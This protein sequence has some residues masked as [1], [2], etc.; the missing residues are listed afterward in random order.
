MEDEKQ[1]Q[2]QLQLTLQRRMEK[3]SPE[4][5]SE[6]LFKRGI[7]TFKCLLCGSED[8]G[9]PQCNLLQSGP[10]GSVSKTFVDYIKL[11]ADGPPFSLMHYQYR[12][13]CRNCGF[14]HHLSVWPVLKWIEEGR[15]DGKQ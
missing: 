5:L 7:E 15:E 1:R 8:I 6:F 12:I 11:D 13:I 2:M 3:V 10:D 14:T 9:I 4:L